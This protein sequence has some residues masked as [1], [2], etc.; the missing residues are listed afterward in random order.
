MGSDR[1][2]AENASFRDAERRRLLERQLNRDLNSDSA[3][4]SNALE[5]TVVRGQLSNCRRQRDV[6]RAQ[7]DDLTLRYEPPRN[8]SNN[9][10][11]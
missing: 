11:P 3:A 2:A 7:C 9:S 6:A 8:S 1:L 10:L 4:Q 5:L